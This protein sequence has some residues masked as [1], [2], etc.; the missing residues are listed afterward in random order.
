MKIIDLRTYSIQPGRIGEYVKLYAEHGLPVQSRHLG[1]PLGYY[2]TE[3]GALNQ[4][5]HLWGYDSQADREEK[6]AALEA[7]PDWT[8]YRKKSTALGLIVAQENKLLKAAGPVASVL[9]E[10]SR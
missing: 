1:Q 2:V 6:R 8:A 10:Y 4:A 7:D 3:F 5:V 9:S